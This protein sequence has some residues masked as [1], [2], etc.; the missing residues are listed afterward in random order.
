MAIT[1]A[2]IHN[3]DHVIDDT[4]EWGPVAERGIVLGRNDDGTFAIVWPENEGLETREKLS[5]LSAPGWYVE[6]PHNS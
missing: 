4:H 6:C 3:G 2:K 1:L 5:T